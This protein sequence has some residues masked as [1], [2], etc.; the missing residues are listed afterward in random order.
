ML[1]QGAFIRYS[2]SV[3]CA[4]FIFKK[5][6][7]FF[8]KLWYNVCSVKKS[9]KKGHVLHTAVSLMR[10]CP[11]WIR[12][13][14]QREAIGQIYFSLLY[15]HTASL[16]TAVF[17]AKNCPSWIRKMVQREEIGQIYSNLL[18]LHTAKLY[19][20]VFLMKNMYTR[21]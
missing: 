6:I 16:Y 21:I 12:K 18:Y 3:I 17:L 19:A 11:S 10:N 5:G 8:E 4:L 9:V 20:A 7:A 15:L 14:I 2:D 13:M 1:F